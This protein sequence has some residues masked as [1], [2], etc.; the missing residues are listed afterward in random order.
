MLKKYVLASLAPRVQ[1]LG[2]FVAGD[3]VHCVFPA[4]RIEMIGSTIDPT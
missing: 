1:W 4:S 2:T 3:K